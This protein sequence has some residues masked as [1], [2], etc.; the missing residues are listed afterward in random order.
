[1]L[2]FHYSWPYER[3]AGDYY[4]EQCPFCQAS[5]ILLPLK[6][7]R[8]TDAYDGVKTTIILPCCHERLV[9]ERMDDDY[10]WASHWLR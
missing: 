2:D 4:F 6:K 7:S 1:M 10:I 3:V 5:P 9:I 8:V